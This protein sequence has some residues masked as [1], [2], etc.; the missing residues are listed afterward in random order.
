MKHTYEISGMTCMGCR[1]HVE[2][3]LENIEGVNSAQV[4]LHKAEAMRLKGGNSA[5]W[6]HI[7]Y[8]Q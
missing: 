1:S 5:K 3:A 4:D 6:A 7:L 8:K 2:K